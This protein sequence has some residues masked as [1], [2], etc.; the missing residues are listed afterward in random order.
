MADGGVDVLRNLLSDE[1]SRGFKIGGVAD[2]T[3]PTEGID[4]KLMH[5]QRGMKAH[6]ALNILLHQLGGR[7]VNNL[8]DAIRHCRHQECITAKEAGLLRKI[9]RQA[10]DAKHSVRE[11]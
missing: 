10:N 4:E 1:E 3:V 8:S 9:N 5:M 7:G 2:V 11:F 6:M